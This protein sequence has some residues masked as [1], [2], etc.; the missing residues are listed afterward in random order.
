MDEVSKEHNGI[1]Y[2]ITKDIELISIVMLL[3]SQYYVKYPY[4]KTSIPFGY[5]NELVNVFSKYNNHC[6]INTFDE[7]VNNG[8]DFDKPLRSIL[9]DAREYDLFV[10]HLC[11]FSIEIGF[12]NFYYKHKLYFQ[13]VLQYNI[14][15][16][17]EI[18][19]KNML[20][21][22]FGQP[23]LKMYVI[24]GNTFGGCGFQV[25]CKE[26]TYCILGCFG[27][28][29]DLPIFVD[30]SKF[31]EMIIHEFSHGFVNPS[32]ERINISQ[33]CINKIYQS[34]SDGYQEQYGKGNSMIAEQIVRA[35][36]ARIIS[37]FIDENK[38]KELISYDISHGFIL[39]K[40]LYFFLMN[41]YEPKR[42][43]YKD[44]NQFTQCLV[45]K[46]NEFDT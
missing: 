36:T 39:E 23:P 25:S 34:L 3:S 44:F 45:T 22:Y 19:Y 46:I 20:S 2:S 16:I 42:Y 38:G 1:I 30:Q 9:G 43:K 41:E 17:S 14:D 29:N 4:L 28:E 35:I 27:K 6:I 7:M 40:E 37:I 10:D 21:T 32:I 31:T 11:N 15:K 5:I 33:P 26:K 8:F 12:D 18:G 13:Q 24:F